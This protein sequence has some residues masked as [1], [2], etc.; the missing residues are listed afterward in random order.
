MSQTE[1][2]KILVIEDEVALG[3]LIK[4]CLSRQALLDGRT[5]YPLDS[6]NKS[7]NKS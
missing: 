3:D 1:Q 5:Y 6:T 2:Y 7:G 4:L